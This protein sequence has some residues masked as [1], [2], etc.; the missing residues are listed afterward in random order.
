MLACNKVND[1]QCWLTLGKGDTSRII[2][3]YFLSDKHA[4]GTERIIN[5]SVLFSVYISVCVYF[6]L[7]QG[8]CL[9]VCVSV[10]EY[11]GVSRYVC[12]WL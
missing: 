10:S 9:C 12:V 5:S 1:E 11:F 8:A 7:L 4:Y 6:S 3:M 2:L